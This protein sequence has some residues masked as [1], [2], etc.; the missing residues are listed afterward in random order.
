MMKLAKSLRFFLLLQSSALLVPAAIAAQAPVLMRYPNASATRIA[1]VAHDELWVVDRRGGDAQRLA[2]GKL[3]IMMPRFSPGGRW[4]AFTVRCDGGQ[5]VYVMASV[6]GAPRRLT[7]ESASSTQGALVLAWTPDSQAIVFLSQR[8]AQ[9]TK[10]FQ[11]FSVPVVGGL[12][13]RMPLDSAGMLSF[14]PD[15]HTIAYNRIFRNFD[16]RKR[17]VGGQHQEIATYDLNTRQLQRIGNWKGTDT[18]PMWF[19]RRIYLLSDR[20]AG[21]RMNLWVYDLDRKEFRQVTHFSDY[22]I[23]FPSLGG[24]AITFQQGGQLYTLNLSSESL[25]KVNVSVPDDGALTGVHA[26]AVANQIRTTDIADMEDFALSPHGTD[27][28]FSAHGEILK[29]STQNNSSQPNSQNITQTTGIDEDHPAWSLDGKS[30]AY[31]TD[32]SGEQQIALRAA[33]GG[34]ER[35]VT[36]FSTGSL[37]TP[38]WSPAGDRLAVSDANH[39]LWLVNTATASSKLVV[40]DAY[41]EIHDETFSPDG[42]WLAYSTIR[43]N[44]QRALH[45][46]EIASG[47]DTVISSPMESDRLPAFSPDGQ[48]LYFVSMRHELPFVS[49]RDN[50]TGIASL[51]SDGIYVTTLTHDSLGP[52][53]PGVNQVRGA[54]PTKFAATSLPIH[55]DLD[56]LMAR[57]TPLPITPAEIVTM[58]LRGNEVYY[59]TSPPEL[60]D[61][62][63]PG[64]RS[65]LRVFDMQ[66]R[67]DRIVVEDLA[68][69]NLSADGSW[70]LYSVN[71]Q[72]KLGATAA[73]APEAAVLD[74]S[75]LQVTVDPRKEW[76]EMFE[77]AWRLDRDMFYSPEMGGNNWRAVHDAYAKLLPLIGSHNDFMYLLGEMQGELA[78]SHTFIGGG[79]EDPST[80]V[81]TALLGADYALDPETQR[82]RFARIYHGDNTRARFH[83]PLT[84]PGLN[85]QGGDYLLAVNGHELIA[86]VDP[87]SLFLGVTGPVTL[88]VAHTATGARRNIVVNPLQ[89]EMP[90]RQ[91]DWIDR[92]RAKVDRLSTGRVGYL[93]L[94]DFAELGSEDFLQQFYPQLDKQGWI[95]D[96]RWNR[97]GFTSQYVLGIL[98]RHLAGMFVNREGATTT[99]PGAV[100][101]GPMVTLINHFSASDGDQFP[102]YFR[103][104]GLGKVIGTRTWGG[105]RGIKGPWRLMDGTYLTIPKDYLYDTK[106]SWILENTGTEPDQT[107]ESVPDEAVTGNDAQLEAAVRS[108]QDELNAHPPQPVSVPS[109]LPAYPPNGIVPPASFED[110]SEHAVPKTR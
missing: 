35:L 106:G 77:K 81:R 108:V 109:A 74:L 20:G 48:L 59:Q 44:Q 105:V 92:T 78:S 110:S 90:L 29:V 36:S 40:R 73:D 57:A 66:G 25:Q 26:L 88:S 84:E 12:P 80:P 17:Y 87:L 2:G 101:R 19:G 93:F 46:Y 30:L 60:I 33:T 89:T 107:V 86:P 96:V 99:L 65:A 13:V 56:G 28:L 47:Q 62:D 42:R 16:P 27:V 18:D 41:A 7:Y 68:H 23:D 94:S 76:A 53:A 63:F 45:L 71:G 100:A 32:S 5:D 75:G 34:A 15:G 103:K 91:Q 4:I 83:S 49:D 8:M 98:Q 70:V 55:I 97:G 51:K 52:L 11:A 72:W 82:Y 37:Y 102:Y 79:H 64:E 50:G 1:F 95:F 24:N 6:G 61:G 3:H 69:Y 9:N 39:A 67:H 22:D 21:W 43:P 14:A 85:L 104:D 54:T 58:E 38:V 31:V 10:V